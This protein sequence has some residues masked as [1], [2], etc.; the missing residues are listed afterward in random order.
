LFEAIDIKGDFVVCAHLREELPKAVG[1]RKESVRSELKRLEEKLVDCFDIKVGDT[2][3]LASAKSLLCYGLKVPL[4]VILAGLPADTPKKHID[5]II[6][7]YPS[8]KW[9]SADDAAKIEEG[10]LACANKLL[11]E[12][13]KKV[14][15]KEK[16]AS[17]AGTNELGKRYD[18]VKESVKRDI[19]EKAVVTEEEKVE[20][21]KRRV[22]E[23]SIN[24]KLDEEAGKKRKEE[25]KL[26][27]Q[28]KQE[29]DEVR[30]KAWKKDDQEKEI[31]E[32]NYK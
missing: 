20:E 16:E 30:R 2:F 1:I 22:T 17:K 29:S 25:K 26:E 24:I 31:R 6:R 14:R 18:N 9:I 5:R 3:L 28:L 12:F 7:D 27:E 32:S 15:E 13:D 23:R 19:E 4:E 11:A 10:A 21:R 8:A